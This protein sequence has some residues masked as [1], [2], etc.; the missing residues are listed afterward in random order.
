[1][2]GKRPG[3]TAG[4][5]PTSVSKQFEFSL[6]RLMKTLSQA[7][8]YF[9]RCIKSNNEK[10]PNYF[11]DNIILRQLRYTGMLETVRIR[12]AGY[13]VRIEYE[14]FKQQYRYVTV[15]SGARIRRKSNS[16][17]ITGSCCRRGSRV[18]MR[19]SSSS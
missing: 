3:S 17:H 1:M 13:S 19:T 7:S 14:A 5:K 9:I 8:P 11:D 10:I 6:I 12:R 15:L 18:R 16:S 2:I 4:S